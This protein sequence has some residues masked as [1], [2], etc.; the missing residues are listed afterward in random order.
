MKVIIMEVCGKLKGHI[1]IYVICKNIFKEII[2]CTEFYLHI[3][4]KA[5]LL[6]L[7]FNFPPMFV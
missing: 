3:V 4:S 1:I 6:F 2:I 7:P 5:H